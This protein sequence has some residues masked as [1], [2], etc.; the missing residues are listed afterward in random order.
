[1]LIMVEVETE[2]MGG[3][4]DRPKIGDEPLVASFQRKRNGAKVRVRGV[5]RPE[6]S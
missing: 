4:A 1:M 2:Q 6:I 3:E 5:V